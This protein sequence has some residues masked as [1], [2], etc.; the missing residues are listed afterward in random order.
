MVQGEGHESGKTDEWLFENE[1][2]DVSSK[3]PLEVDKTTQ[4]NLE[5]WRKGLYHFSSIAVWTQ[6]Q[7]IYHFKFPNSHIKKNLK[8]LTLVVCFNSIYNV[9]LIHNQYKKYQW[10]T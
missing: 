6:V 9:I 3:S 1:I 7:G 10:D 8:K 5:A 4:K 2:A